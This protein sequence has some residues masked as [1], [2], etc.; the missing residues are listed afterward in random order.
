MYRIR[1]SHSK[2]AGSIQTD[3]KLNLILSRV[4]NY[5]TFSKNPTF[6]MKF[7]HNLQRQLSGLIVRSNCQLSN[8]CS[9]IFK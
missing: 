7:L 8:F 5:E 2:N 1:V 9:E 3:T 4:K 6:G